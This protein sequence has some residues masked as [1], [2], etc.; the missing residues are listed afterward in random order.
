[1]KQAVNQI[2]SDRTR[3]A[4]GDDKDEARKREDEAAKKRKTERRIK[5][6]IVE[7]AESLERI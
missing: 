5:T 1:M 4:A 7:D 6:A 3:S 2:G